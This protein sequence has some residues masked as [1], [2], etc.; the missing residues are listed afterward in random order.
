MSTSRNFF[1]NLLPKF[2]KRVA[3]N[4][5]IKFLALF[6]PALK[7]IAEGLGKERSMDSSQAR[8]LLGWNPRSAREAVKSAAESAKEFGLIEN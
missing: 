6:L 2:P 7:M 8:N 4:W 5:L 3:P 1:Q